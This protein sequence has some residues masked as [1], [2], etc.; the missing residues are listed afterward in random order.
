MTAARARNEGFAALL[1]LKPDLQ[2]V[3]FVDGD[4][5]LIGGWFQIALAFMTEHSDA[6]AVCGRR[7]ERHPEKSIYNR[8]MDLE[9]NT[10]IG[11]TTAC[12]GDSLMRARAFAEVNGFTPNLIAGEEPELCLRLRERGWKI[13]RLDAEMTN[14]DASMTRFNQW[15]RRGVRSGYGGLDVWSRHKKVAPAALKSQLLRAVLWGFAIPFVTLFGCF[16]SFKM[17][18]M[19]AVYPVQVARMAIRQRFNSRESWFYALLI[20]ISKFAEVEGQ[21][22]FCW[23]SLKRE[24]NKLIEYK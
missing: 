11:E 16:I 1:A 20:T 4:C 12:G 14:H 6:A 19:L 13:Y 8:L 23:V 10:P 7:R 22:K 5:V 15:W 3:L 24:S 9:W 2:F 21:L 17:L 18:A